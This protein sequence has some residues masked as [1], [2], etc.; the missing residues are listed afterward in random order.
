[1]K[2]AAPPSS[3]PQDDRAG[4][5]LEFLG[6]MR[7]VIQAQRDVVLGYLGTEAGAVVVERAPLENAARLPVQEA[8]LMEAVASTEPPP[9]EDEQAPRAVGEILL[10][11]VSDRTGYPAEMIGMDMDLEGDLSISEE[12]EAATE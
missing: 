8:V 10:E 11:L 7:E 12:S 1:M 9:S 5:V 2:P 6:S 3:S 4:V